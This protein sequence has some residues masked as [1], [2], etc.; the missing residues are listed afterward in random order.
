MMAPRVS[1]PALRADWTERE[2]AVIGLARSGRAVATLLARNGHTVYAS[3]SANT[4][5]LQETGA[6]LEREQV[7]VD[8]G[9]HNMDRVLRSSLVVVSPGVPPDTPVIAQA[10][11]KGI[12]VVNE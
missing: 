7:A 3:D 12:D 1:T 6:A 9:T 4:P 11:R 2:I 5:T 10:Q 8:L